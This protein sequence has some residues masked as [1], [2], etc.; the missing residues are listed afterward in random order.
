MVDYQGPEIL[1]SV[2]KRIRCD[3]F[4]RIVQMELIGFDRAMV[5]EIERMRGLEFVR[6][7]VP[8]AEL[9]E[10]LPKS[11]TCDQRL[12]AELV[13]SGYR[14]NGQFMATGLE[15]RPNANPVSQAPYDNAE[16]IPLAD[17]IQQISVRENP[18]NSSSPQFFCV[19]C[20]TSPQP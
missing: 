17:Y 2:L 12:I 4:E 14:F 20:S 10:R 7:A 3:W 5:P 18:S 6:W 13:V 16:T 19:S 11:S 9:Q 8:T 15:W 1:K